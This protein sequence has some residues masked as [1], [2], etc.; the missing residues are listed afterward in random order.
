MRGGAK[1]MYIGDLSSPD[2][3]GVPLPEQAAQIADSLL[4]LMEHPERVPDSTVLTA[5]YVERES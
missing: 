1:L 2:A 5:Q 3:V 4:L